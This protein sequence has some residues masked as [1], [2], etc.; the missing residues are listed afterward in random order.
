[1]RVCTLASSSSGNCA[2]VSRGSTH[3]LIDAGISLRRIKAGLQLIGLSPGDLGG[4]LVTHD[5]I[6]HV[7]GIGML[8]KHFKTPVFLS[9][10]ASDGVS[11]AHPESEPFLNR[12]ETGTGFD[13]GGMIV[14]SF[15]TP[16]DA[17]GSVGYTF[18]AD[19]TKLVYATDLGCVT[20]EVADAAMGADVAVLEANHD[21]DMLK[22][23]AYPP[24]LK[25]R[26][27]SGTGHLANNDCGVFASHLAVSGTRYIMLAHLSRENNTPG[28][29]RSAVEM[30]LGDVGLIAGKD[31]QLDVSPP[32]SISRILDV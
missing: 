15:S 14:R 9:F 12:F 25:K 21:R 19:G 30:S 11:S 24:F 13:F 1:M 4:L 18:E 23:S 16:H 22:S 32:D 17:Y 29:A 28:L 5:H 8:T 3:L 2:V 27:L 6:D 10:G 7:S 26:I 20:G 31:I